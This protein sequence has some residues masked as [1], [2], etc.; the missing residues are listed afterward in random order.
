MRMLPW[1]VVM[2]A[3]SVA[4]P[5]AYGQAGAAGGA[6]G[7]V[8][9]A[10]IEFTPGAKAS[11]MTA[12]AK[13]QLQASSAFALTQSKRFDVVDVRRTR[14]ASQGN[15]QA[16]NSEST[17]AAAVKVGKQLG[18]AYVLT[19]TVSEYTLKGADDFG[20]ATL[21]TRLVE[22][23]TGAVTYSGDTVQQGT[24]AMRTTGATEM[25]TKVLK[26]A[27]EQLTATLVA[28]L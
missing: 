6:S 28:K 8:K 26:P 24:S 27:I 15:L 11:E 4:V 18:V 13:R 17:T 5:A 7:K 3:M 20:Y 10:V 12:E 25:Q 2:A 23:A 22:V 21:R 19:G 9:V 1:A 16:V 14:E